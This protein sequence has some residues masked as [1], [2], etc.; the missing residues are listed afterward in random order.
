MPK[1]IDPVHGMINFDKLIWDF[2]DTPHFQ[3]LRKLKQL[4]TLDYVFPC[5]THTRYDHSIG[6]AHLARIF[7]EK[8]IKNNPEK[9]CN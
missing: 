7:I 8:L 9:Y 5:A 1:N 2:I 6:T 4:G 3:R